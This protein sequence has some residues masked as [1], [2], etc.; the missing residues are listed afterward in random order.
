M[1]QQ[2][3]KMDIRKVTGAN[4]GD[5][6][7][8]MA[9]SVLAY[10]PAFYSA[11]QVEAWHRL[12]LM[13]A[14]ALPSEDC[15]AYVGYCEGVPAAVGAWRREGVVDLLYVAPGFIRRGIGTG[16]LQFIERCMGESG[17]QHKTAQV[18]KAAERFFLSHGYCIEQRLSV[19]RLGQHFDV[20]I[21][22][23]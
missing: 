23:K 9:G 13:R 22:K 16:M 15:H 3:Q 14:S 19:E 1:E 7:A 20:C 10:G 8:V 6:A 18:S 2:A 4:V 5:L 17:V 12:V 11:A 21:M